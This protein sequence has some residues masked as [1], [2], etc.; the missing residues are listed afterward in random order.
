MQGCPELH[1]LSHSSESCVSMPRQVVAFSIPSKAASSIE[2]CFLTQKDTPVLEG[3]IDFP[4]RTTF[5]DVEK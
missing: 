2:C 4:S 5:K 3:G 1:I